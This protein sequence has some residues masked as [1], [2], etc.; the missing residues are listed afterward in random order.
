MIATLIDRVERELEEVS[1]NLKTLLDEQAQ[2]HQTQD[3]WRDKLQGG[4]GDNQLQGG[5]AIADWL[6]F[7]LKAD[8]ELKN[9]EEK[10]FLVQERIT[11]CRNT[12]L[13]LARRKDVLTHVLT[14]RA[15]AQQHRADRRRERDVAQRA[16]ARQAAKEDAQRWR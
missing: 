16:M 7:G 14:R 8:R 12:L 2:L 13:L 11:D 6:N 3:Y 9:L 5:M 15:H 1:R 10:D 4:P